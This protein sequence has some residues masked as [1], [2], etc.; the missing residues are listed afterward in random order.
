[1]KE[2][3]SSIDS[4][5]QVNC[6]FVH[7]GDIFPLEVRTFSLKDQKSYWNK[8]VPNFFS[9]LWT[10]GELERS[11][12]NHFQT[13]WPKTQ[14]FFLFEVRKYLPTYISQKQSSKR[15]PDTENPV[16]RNQLK[17]FRQK[18]E[19]FWPT[20]RNRWQNYVFFWHSSS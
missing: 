7:L 15:D 19:K 20:P 1:M 14:Q 18:F 9:T 11:F 3:F 5:E 4:S 6:N 16:F 2:L 8:I 13:V 10:L 17:I 12:D